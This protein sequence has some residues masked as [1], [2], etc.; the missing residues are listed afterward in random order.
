M[1]NISFQNN[2]IEN[3]IYNGIL[4]KNKFQN[5]NKNQ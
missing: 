5:N 3:H 1:K 2:Q 4:L